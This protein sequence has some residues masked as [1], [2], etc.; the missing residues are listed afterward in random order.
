[1]ENVIEG[2]TLIKAQM[3]RD[4]E[5]AVPSQSKSPRCRMEIVY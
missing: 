2:E 1:M 5:N 4:M 3:H